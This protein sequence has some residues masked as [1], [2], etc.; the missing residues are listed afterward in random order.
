MK[1]IFNR[2]MK[3]FLVIMLCLVCFV[4]VCGIGYYVVVSKYSYY[5]DNP[6]DFPEE[7]LRMPLRRIKNNVEDKYVLVHYY[8][9]NDERK[10]VYEYIDDNEF[11]RDNKKKFILKTSKSL[12]YTTTQSGFNL[13]K[14]GQKIDRALYEGEVPFEEFKDRF[15]KVDKNQLQ[16][17]I[18]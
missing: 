11:L 13:Y 2:L 17:V 6:D 8:Y 3:L 7:V 1:K 15:I 14:N 5:L 4:G 12:Y 18:N 9:D 16:D 10:T